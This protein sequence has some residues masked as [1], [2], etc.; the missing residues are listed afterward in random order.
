MWII[1]PPYDSCGSA[2]TLSLSLS[3]PQNKHDKHGY[4][5]RHEASDYA[6]DDGADRGDGPRVVSTTWVL[7]RDP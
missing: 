2:G 1:S 5:N 3:P 4:A 6:A 7:R